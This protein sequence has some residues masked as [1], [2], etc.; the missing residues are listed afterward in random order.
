MTC[1]KEGRKEGRKGRQGKRGRAPKVG[2]K[3]N[4]LVQDSAV[5]VSR[6]SIVD[7]P[8][9]PQD[10]R[11]MQQSKRSNQ[12][13]FTHSPF[14]LLYSVPSKSRLQAQDQQQ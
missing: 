13:C 3:T 6:K 2:A 14:L 12:I 10:E 7:Y 8:F 5:S 4:T 1:W 11:Q 9:L